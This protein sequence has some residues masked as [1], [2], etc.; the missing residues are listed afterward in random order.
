MSKGR[1]RWMS[2]LNREQIYPSFAFLFYLGPWQIAWC[3]P[4]LMRVIFFT[5]P[6]IKVLIFSRNTLTGTPRN[7]ILPAIWA[8]LSQVKLTYEVNR[9]TLV[10][11]V[12]YNSL[13]LTVGEI[14]NMMGY[15]FCDQVTNQLTL[16][17]SEGRI[18]LGLPD[19]IS[20]ALK[21]G[22][23]PS[24]GQRFYEK[25]I[26]LLTLKLKPAIEEATWQ[27]AVG[28]SKSWEWTWV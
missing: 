8:L 9:H 1:R 3:P 19:L 7:K 5:Q 6:T 17:S 21:R 14:M 23:D 24:W 20:W 12:V 18:I 16:S 22:M 4:T 27:G 11:H 26:P 10:W 15:H 25:K 28:T 2:Q 13:P